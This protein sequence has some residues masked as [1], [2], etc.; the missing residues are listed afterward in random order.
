MRAL[1]L[2]RL[3][4][5]ISPITVKELSGRMRNAHTYTVLTVYLA[6]VSGLAVLLYAVSFLS[7]PRTIGGNGAVGTAVFY[8]L[9]GMQVLLVS[10]VAP[11]FAVGA[12][13]QERERKTFDLLR[14]TLLTPGQIVWAKL[15]A[16]LGFVLLLIFA[17]LP[18]FSLVFMLGG[19]EPF[20]LIIVL[21]VV[22]AAALLFSTLA[23]YV[24]SRSQ[25]TVGATIVTYAVVL[26]IVIGIP[27][28]ALIGSSTVQLALAPTSA[29]GRGA[30]LLANLFETLLTLAI[31][32]SPVSAIVA[33]QRFFA[34]SGELWTFS[35]AFFG[36]SPP[37]VLP[38]PFV[39]LSV[40]YVIAGIA[41]F[42]M[43][44]QRIARAEES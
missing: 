4:I 33:S 42:V 21:C 39:I 2:P 36:T 32:L 28:A 43:T 30:Q 41:L 9:V 10:F 20:E 14:I 37:P 17:T 29:S 22:L 23:L 35:P 38:S 26:G 24:S 15:I 12:I 27:L 16:A 44:V 5:R 18:L 1:T 13:A 3:S 7:G 34:M 25:T 19:V 40:A 31:S 11:A 6:I 8:F